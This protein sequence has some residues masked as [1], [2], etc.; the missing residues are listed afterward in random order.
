MSFKV[1]WIDGKREP[2]CAP[3]PN[4]PSGADVDM[5]HDAD[6]PSCLC[7][8]PYP[9]RRCGVYAVECSKCASRVVVTT[10]GRADDPRS[11][12]VTCKKN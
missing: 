11:V 3:N 1:K 5:R 2:Q 8:L 6:E 7:D 4:H 10:A 9:A 12:R